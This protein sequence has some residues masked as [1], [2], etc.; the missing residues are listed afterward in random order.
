MSLRAWLLASYTN[1]SAKLIPVTK[2]DN[3]VNGYLPANSRFVKQ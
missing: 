1:F 3:S 2:I